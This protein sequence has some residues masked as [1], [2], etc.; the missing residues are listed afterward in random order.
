VAAQNGC[1]SEA[2]CVGFSTRESDNKYILKNL[3]SGSAPRLG[4]LVPKKTCDINRA[5]FANIGESCGK[6]NN[7]YNLKNMNNTQKFIICSIINRC[8][9][10]LIQR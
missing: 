7:N 6:Q 3:I 10:F 2:D 4:F 1:D 9:L 8:Y 5:C